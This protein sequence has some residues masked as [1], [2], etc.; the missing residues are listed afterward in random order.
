[1]PSS[2]A[3]PFTWQH[4]KRGPHLFKGNMLFVVYGGGWGIKL[5]TRGECNMGVMLEILFP[6]P[7]TS[8]KWSFLHFY[9]TT[10]HRTETVHNIIHHAIIVSLDATKE[11]MWLYCQFVIFSSGKIWLWGEISRKSPSLQPI[12]RV[13]TAHLSA[14]TASYF[15][16]CMQVTQACFLAFAYPSRQHSQQWVFSPELLH[17]PELLQP[18]SQKKNHCLWSSRAWLLLILLDSLGCQSHVNVSPDSWFRS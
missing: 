6:L 7:S 12:H 10:H 13:L 9:V 2:P 8:P 17:L 5:K 3:L 14:R 11:H 1:M 4:A 18:H 16:R 15:V